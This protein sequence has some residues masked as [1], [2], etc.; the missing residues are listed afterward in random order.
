MKSS[1][2]IFVKYY[3][4]R[5]KWEFGVN[6]WPVNDGNSYCAR[7]ACATDLATSLGCVLGQYTKPFNSQDLIAN[8]PP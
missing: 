3:H 1:P 4:F 2:S 5:Y 6:Q 7:E 8:S